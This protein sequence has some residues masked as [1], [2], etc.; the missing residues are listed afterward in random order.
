M[1][2][3]DEIRKRW[4]AVNGDDWDDG[5]IDEDAA[6][7]APIDVARLLAEIDNLRA[8]AERAEKERDEARAEI[9]ALRYDNALVRGTAKLECDDRKR[10]EAEVAALRKV[11]DAAEAACEAHASRRADRTPYL[12]MKTLRAALDAA[13]GEESE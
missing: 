5:D 13:R 3:I 8:R 4:D 9:E 1:A 6:A 11:R 12:A 7:H 10:A 2:T